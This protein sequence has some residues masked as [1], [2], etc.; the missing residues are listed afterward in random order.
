MLHE[1]RIVLDSRL[2][3]IADM[4]GR[5]E[6]YA[7]IGC[8]HGRLGAFLLQRGW[9]NQALLMD[10]S[11][12]SLDKARALIRLLGFESKTRFLV[13]DG[14]EPLDC[15]VDCVVIAGMGGTTAASIIERG[16]EKF[17]DARLILQANVAVPELRK[18]LVGIGYRISDERVVKDGR[19]HY[20]ILEAVPG[21]A[22]YSELE[23]MVGPV[24]LKKKPKELTGYAE[25]RLRVAQKALVGAERGDE[26]AVVDD[27]RKE[28]KIWEDVLADM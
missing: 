13:G 22:E 20:I 10:I 19:R 6:V 28:K 26:S 24:L 23:L 11:D 5:C 3:T 15:A 9:V 21:N 4:V 8:D 17:G 16:R 1:K 18:C 27:L 2:S 14:A 12:P 7:D 25:F